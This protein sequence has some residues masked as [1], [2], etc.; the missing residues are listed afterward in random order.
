[1]AM[2]TLGLLAMAPLAASEPA[3][4]ALYQC[5]PVASAPVLDGR[6][7][8]ECWRDRPF[9]SGW[10]QYWTPVPKPPLLHTGARL[11][12]DDRALYIGITL[13]DEQVD[14]IR[15]TISGRDDPN[16]WQ[17]DCVEIMVDPA[18]SGTGYRKFTTNFLA[19]RYDELAT[20]AG[21]NAGW[22]AEGWQVRTSKGADGWAIEAMFP[23]V[24]LGAKPKLGDLWSFDLVRYGYSTGSFRGVTWSLGGSYASPQS[25]GYLRFGPMVVPDDAML[26]QIARVAGRTKGARFRLLVQEY[27]LVL[28]Y[29]APRGWHQEEIVAW[30]R[31]ALTVAARRLAEGEAA[32]ARLGS[33]DDRARLAAQ[34]GE[35]RAQLRAL[36]NMPG[37]AGGF[38]ASAATQTRNAALAAARKADEVKWEA[39]LLA[40]VAAD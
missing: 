1:M 26:A 10:Y 28:T 36:A 38:S 24:D 8:D 3:E 22:N 25:F 18:S 14:K 16:T 34:L 11:C 17:D 20:D 13:D 4:V 5:E 29:D 40:L 32:V 6:L 31:S 39:L 15:A 23:W 12:Y 27:G 37:D 7:T 21:V 33:A 35:T 19:A 2:L 9:L 30:V